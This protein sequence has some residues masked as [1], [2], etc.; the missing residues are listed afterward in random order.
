[1]RQTVVRIKGEVRWNFFHDPDSKC[2][3]A[4]CDEL[5]LDVFGKTMD[6]LWAVAQEAIRELLRE[7]FE[8]GDLDSFL[9]NKGWKPEIPIRKVPE[10]RGPVFLLPSVMAEAD[11]DTQKVYP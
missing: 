6:D 1:M 9:R 2:W 11:Y 4:F 5:G 8:T 3:I 7:L 10:K